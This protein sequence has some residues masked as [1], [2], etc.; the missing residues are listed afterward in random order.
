[1]LAGIAVLLDSAILVVGA[2]IVGPE[3]GALAGLCT[4]TVRRSWDLVRRSALALVVGFPVGIFATVLLTWF[5]TAIGLVDETYL[6][7]PRPQTSFIF[8]PDA[9]SFVIALLAGVAGMLA[10]TSAKSGAVIGVLVSVTTIPAAGNVGVA[11][12]YGERHQAWT[13]FEQLVT[14][15]GGILVAGVLTL[16]VQLAAWRHV[17]RRKTY[18]HALR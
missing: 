11:L 13:S 4:G 16:L 7:R 2:M 9:M 14:N 6:T 3:F 10:L 17:G 15:L 12:A 18:L 8:N 1:M 5:V